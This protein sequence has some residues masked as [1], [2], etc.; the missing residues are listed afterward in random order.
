MRVEGRE[1]DKV[2]EREEQGR[3]N[4][5]ENDSYR[6]YYCDSK[7]WLANF[8]IMDKSLKRGY[9]KTINGQWTY[10]LYIHIHTVY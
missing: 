6:K 8:P 5:P 4:F 9:L 3:K 10:K 7:R 1:G 2:G